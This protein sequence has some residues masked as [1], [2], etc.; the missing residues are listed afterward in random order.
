MLDLLNRAKDYQGNNIQ[1]YG[2]ST[3]ATCASNCTATSDCKGAF[4]Y[5]NH[6]ELSTCRVRV[7]RYA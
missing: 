3:L 2:P 4:L 1:C 6:G 5:D 7:S